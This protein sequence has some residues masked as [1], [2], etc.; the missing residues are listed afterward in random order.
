MYR[1]T[2]IKTGSYL[3]KDKRYDGAETLNCEVVYLFMTRNFSI[4]FVAPSAAIFPCISR[5]KY[6]FLIRISQEPSD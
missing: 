6:S 5:G 2:H 4:P 1:V 3:L